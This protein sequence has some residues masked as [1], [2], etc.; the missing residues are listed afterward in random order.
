M[1]E[2]A[3]LSLVCQTI[4]LWWFNQAVKFLFRYRHI[5]SPFLK[6]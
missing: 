3:S 4:K 6:N 5:L 2:M 1:K